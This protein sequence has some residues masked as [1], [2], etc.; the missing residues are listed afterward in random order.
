MGVNVTISSAFA[1]APGSVPFSGLLG[2][3]VMLS[4]EV[5]KCG[6]TCVYSE[7]NSSK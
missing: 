6:S 1:T 5:T 7:E 3:C 4:C 2:S